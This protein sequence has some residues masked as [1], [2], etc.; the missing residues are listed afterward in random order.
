MLIA[1]S[2]KT[3]A[4]QNIS[5]NSDILDADM[6]E[7]YCKELSAFSS[8]EI[9]GAL[10]SLFEADPGTVLGCLDEEGIYTLLAKY[11]VYGQNVTFMDT[12]TFEV[13]D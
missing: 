10:L 11:M 6:A 9:N 1:E 7:A 5:K 2:L 12:D 13:E 4:D 3:K 8:D